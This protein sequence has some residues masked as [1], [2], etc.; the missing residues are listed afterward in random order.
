MSALKDYLSVLSFL[1]DNSKKSRLIDIVLKNYHVIDNDVDVCSIEGAQIF[2]EVWLAPAWGCDT[3]QKLIDEINE[4]VFEPEKEI[5]RLRESRRME[6]DRLDWLLSRLHE[7]TK[8]HLVG[9]MSGEADLGDWR[10]LI[11]RAM[12]NEE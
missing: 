12:Q 1:E 10:L 3:L 6:G 4:I 9:E 8:R 5:L 2:E 11:D 7:D